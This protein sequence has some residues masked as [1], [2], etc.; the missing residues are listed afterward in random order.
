MAIRHRGRRRAALSTLLRLVAGALVATACAAAPPGPFTATYTLSMSGIP[1][2][3]V[4]RRL[5]NEIGG[6]FVFRSETRASGVAR[7]F[8]SDHLVEESIWTLVRGGPRPLAYSYRHTGGD[9]LR[10]QTITFDWQQRRIDNS[11]D[12]RRWRLATAPQLLDKLLYQLAIMSDLEDGR[13]ELIYRFVDGGEIK[14][15][16]FANRGEEVLETPLGPVE[17][18][19]L[20]RIT[21]N[22][23]KPTT[24]LWCAPRWGHLPVRLDG[25]DRRGRLISAVIRT[26]RTDRTSEDVR[27]SSRDRPPRAVSDLR[28]PNR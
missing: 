2:A 26:R 17:T 27:S 4:E 8:R 6:R 11:E 5:Y 21:E 1:I 9:K 3:T 19:K 23:D 24:T 15:Y 14:T 20:V 16:R 10:S 25:P 18:V 28:T 13:R 22:S 12:G 7:L